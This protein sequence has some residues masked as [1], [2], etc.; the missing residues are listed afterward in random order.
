MCIF[1]RINLSVI[2]FTKADVEVEH[3]Q[4][5]IRQ[6]MVHWVGLH[7]AT[8]WHADRLDIRDSQFLWLG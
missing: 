7:Q 8:A 2:S 5:E 6:S 3:L 4:W 1:V